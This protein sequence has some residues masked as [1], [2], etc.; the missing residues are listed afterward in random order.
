MLRPW[1]FPEYSP[2]EQLV[3]EKIKNIVSETYQQFGFTPIMT[4]AVEKNEILLKGWEDSSKQIF[5]LYWLAQWPEDTK[6]YSLHFDLTVPFARY[7]LDHQNEIVFPFKRSQIQPVWRWE[8]R[9]RWRFNEFWQAD[10]D[11]IWENDE[12][13]YYDAEVIYTAMITLQKIFQTFFINTWLQ[14]HISNR[15][16]I[17]WLSDELLDKDLHNDFFKLVD[18]YYKIWQQK[19]EQDLEQICKNN[20]KNVGSDVFQRILDFTKLNIEN[21]DQLW[22]K[23]ELWEQW[24]TELKSVFSFLEKLNISTNY[25][26]KFD[27]FIMRWLDYYTW[28][29]VETFLQDDFEIGSICSWWR[30]ENLTN[31]IDPKSR[32][33]KWVWISIWLSRLTTIIIEKL[34]LKENNRPQTCTEYLFV[35]FEETIW[36]I[37]KLA[38]KFVSQW[39]KIE[40]FPNAKKLW[41]QFAYAD[42]KWIPFVIVLWEWELQKWIYKLKNMQS[43]EE[44]EKN[45]TD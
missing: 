1:W 25:N 12:N 3:F 44:I 37:L 27:P 8:R 31:L 15:K 13:L 5:G 35:N 30:Y 41:K 23:N 4:P 19:F 32:N 2:W 40:I 7:V 20:T 9:Q 17:Q 28:I 24:I 21:L 14:M 42:K 6:K 33:Y 38:S 36:E 39:K 11:V 18:D 22:I 10:I 43:W 34:N 16:I 29:V 26:F 45:L